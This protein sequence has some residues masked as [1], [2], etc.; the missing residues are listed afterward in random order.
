MATRADTEL[1]QLT[2]KKGWEVRFLAIL[3]DSCNVRL[4]CHGAGIT[5][6]CAYKRR[7]KSPAF[8]AAWAEAEDE[9]VEL[10]EAKARSRAMEQ[11][12]TLMIFLL[13]AHRPK[14]YRENYQVDLTSGGLPFKIYGGFDPSKV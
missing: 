11:S 10:L 5:R 14:K 8:A 4:A 13:K 2:P 7:G 1:S 12:D 6:Q 9:S 3:R